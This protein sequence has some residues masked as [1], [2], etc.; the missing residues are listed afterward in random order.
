MGPI[1][2]PLPPTATQM[3]ISMD[4][5]TPILAGVMMPTWPT[6]SA[7]AIPARTADTVKTKSLKAAGE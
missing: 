4:G 7:P 5:S 1:S 2:V 3:I 6:Y